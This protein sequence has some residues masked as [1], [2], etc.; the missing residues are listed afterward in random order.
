MPGIDFRQLRAEIT[1]AEVL[2][3]LGIVVMERKGDQVRGRCPFHEPSACGKHRAFSAN[4]RRHIFHCFKCQ[5][6]GNQLDLWVRAS[7]KTIH[8]AALELCARLHKD[9]PYLENRRPA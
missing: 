9:V 7:K 5:A 8:E 2:D 3:L 6:G 4:L 1:M